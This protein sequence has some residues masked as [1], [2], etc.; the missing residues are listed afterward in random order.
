MV[1][2]HG[3]GTGVCVGLT[4]KPPVETLHVNRKE[5]QSVRV[6]QEDVDRQADRQGRGRSNE[7]EEEEKEG[8][9]LLSIWVTF[10]RSLTVISRQGPA[11]ESLPIRDLNIS[12]CNPVYRLDT[13]MGSSNSVYK[14]PFFLQQISC[15]EV[16][17]YQTWL[18]AG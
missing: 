4:A 9:S 2:R 3:S 8:G 18:L 10:V 11:Q 17:L 12:A 15:R 16:N 13:Q 14:N 7:E 6:S 5:T 1:E